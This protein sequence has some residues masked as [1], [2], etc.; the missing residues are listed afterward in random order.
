MRKEKESELVSHSLSHVLLGLVKGQVGGNV[1][2]R[3]PVNKEKTIQFFYLQK[4]NTF[5]NGFHTL[6]EIHTQRWENTRLDN[7]SKTAVLM[8]NLNITH[9]GDYKC[10]INYSDSDQHDTTVIQLSV[11]ANYTKPEVMKSCNGFS[12]RVTCVSYG[13]YPGR[14]MIWDIPGST[15]WQVANSS[16]REDPDTNMVN[17]SSTANFNC[18]GGE[19][20]YLSCYVGLVKS[21]FFSVCE[22]KD[23]VIIATICVLTV[24]VIIVS[25][26][27]WK[28]RKENTGLGLAQCVHTFAYLCV[29]VRWCQYL[30]INSNFLVFQEQYQ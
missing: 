12:C 4:D 2:I 22:S 29:A 18:S 27:V 26:L 23:H 6:R 24:S 8:F 3:C 11:T 14:K 10:I 16:E 17:S 21:N 19:L 13:G 9:S 25:L 1:T 7:N 5:V 20:S 30:V 15:M 28:C